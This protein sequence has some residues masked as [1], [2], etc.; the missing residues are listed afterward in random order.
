MIIFYCMF[1]LVILLLL[2]SKTLDFKFSHLAESAAAS[3]I[4]KEDLFVDIS[5]KR[6][7]HNDRSIL[8]CL[9]HHPGILRPFLSRDKV[10]WRRLGGEAGEGGL[11]GRA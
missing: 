9:Q 4:V 2:S 3:L 7:V 5:V 10:R 6:C 11:K 8:V 1:P